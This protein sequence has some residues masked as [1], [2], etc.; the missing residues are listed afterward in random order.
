MTDDCRQQFEEWISHDPYARS[1]ERIP[2]DPERY[3][4]PGVYRDINTDLAW[5]AWKEAWE[6]G[7]KCRNGC[8]VKQAVQDDNDNV[9]TDFK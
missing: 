1:I 3:A 8:K 6:L 5:Q 2:D 9:T 4:F 7:D